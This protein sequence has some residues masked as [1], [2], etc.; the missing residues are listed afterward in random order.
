MVA[1]FRSLV[2]SDWVAVVSRVR[3]RAALNTWITEIRRTDYMV[4]NRGSMDDWNNYARIAGGDSSL[5]W[6]SIL[7]LTTRHENFNLPVTTRN[8]VSGC[9]PSMSSV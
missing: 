8:I 6:N 2:G 5:T 4:Y 7:P 9:L 3:R 1:A